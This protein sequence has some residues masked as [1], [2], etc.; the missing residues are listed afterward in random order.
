MQNRKTQPLS[1]TLHL[2]RSPFIFSFSK[3]SAFVKRLPFLDFWCASL[4]P[5]LSTSPLSIPPARPVFPS[6]LSALYAFALP[7]IPLYPHMNGYK[8]R[9]QF[10]RSKNKHVSVSVA[11]AASHPPRLHHVMDGPCLFA[12]SGVRA[13]TLAPHATER[14]YFPKDPQRQLELL[15]FSFAIAVICPRANLASVLSC[16]F[17][18]VRMGLRTHEQ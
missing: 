3:Y 9:G 13:H 2:L 17:T 10:I 4:Q 12:S 11:P 14:T 18:A 6:P 8:R 1:S 5:F 7:I 16:G 15:F